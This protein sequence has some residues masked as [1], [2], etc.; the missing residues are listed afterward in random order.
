MR[1]RLMG[2]RGSVTI[3]LVLAAAAMT[4]IVGLVV[5]LGGKVHA[6]TTCP[7]CR[8]P[9]RP[10]CWGAGAGRSPPRCA[11]TASVLLL[12][13][14]RS[15]PPNL[16]AAHVQGTVTFVSPTTLRVQVTHSYQPIFLTLLGM[17]AIRIDG[18]ATAYLARAV[19]GAQR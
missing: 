11:A 10:R 4:M 18:E 9:G 8:R 15:S 7:R 16:A 13:R 6:M 17:A 3:W 14:R 5:D 12:E 19:N 1:A 2:E